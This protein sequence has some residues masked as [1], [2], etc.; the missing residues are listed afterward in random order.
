MPRETS[1]FYTR[2]AIRFYNGKSLTDIS[3]YIVREVPLRL[4]VNGKL[5]ITIACLGIHLRELAVGFLRSEGIVTAI[6]D[7]KDIRIIQGDE[8]TR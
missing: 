5:V 2:E 3:A 6:E 7:L 1:R 8:P 4:Y